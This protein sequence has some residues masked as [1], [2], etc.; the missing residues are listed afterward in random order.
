MAASRPAG[1]LLQEVGVVDVS[2]ENVAGYFLL[3]EMTFQTK[4]CVAFVEQ[5]LVDRA[6]RRMADHTT[7][8]DRLMLIN[9]GAALLGVALKA[10]FVSAQE[11]KTPA[12]ERLLD[13]GAA[14]FDR[15][16]FMRVVTIGATHFAFQ[17]RMVVRQL[18]LCP[19]FQ[20]TLET[21]FGRLPRINDRTSSAAGLNVQTPG[22][23]AG[24]AAHALCVLS[25]RHQPG[26]RCGAKVA[27][28][29][30]VAGLTF[31]CTDELRAGNARRRENCPVCGAARKQNYGQRRCSPDAPKQFFALTVDPPS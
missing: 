22:A 3:L 20:V 24:L 28:N 7:L 15:D 23:V 26:M 16:P 4:R 17:H 19:H 12:F 13:V 6:V 30:F 27:H 25:F 11:S 29:L 9:P 1:S 5:S 10:S 18:E 14:A 31:F 2:N 8:T 21:S